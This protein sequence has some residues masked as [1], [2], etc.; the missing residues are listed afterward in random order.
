MHGRC[1]GAPLCCICPSSTHL[2]WASS[3]GASSSPAP[4]P[5]LL[6]LSCSS[7]PSVFWD[8]F[9]PFTG[10]DKSVKRQAGMLGLLG[11]FSPTPPHPR[12]WTPLGAA[13][14]VVLIHS[15]AHSM[16]IPTVA[17]PRQ[18]LEWPRR[19]NCPSREADLSMD[20][21][22]CPLQESSYTIIKTCS[23]RD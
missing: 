17:L 6:S 9:S 11:Q 21:P 3:L 8:K 16:G 7:V 2:L 19:L 20:F 14:Q 4:G 12:G 1:Q 23:A 22:H 10:P 15:Q 13:Q 5:R 18:L